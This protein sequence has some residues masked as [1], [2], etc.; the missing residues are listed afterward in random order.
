M[1]TVLMGCLLFSL[2]LPAIAA[3]PCCP[4]RAHA[5]PAKVPADLVSLVGKTF[6]TDDSTAQNATFVRCLGTKLVACY[7]RANLV[8]DKADMR[9]SLPGATA[10]CRANPGSQVIPMSATGHGTIYQWSCQ[11]RRAV[12]G[13]AA[14][15]VDPHGYIAEN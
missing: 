5:T 4:N 15:H 11:G 14:I 1:H 12:A 10:W 13:N 9:R 7:V 3:E 8:C 2:A 6:R